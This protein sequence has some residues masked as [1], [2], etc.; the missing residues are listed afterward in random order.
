MR[1]GLFIT[2]EGPDGAGKTTQINRL[3]DYLA[4]MGMDTVLTR[5]PGGTQIGEKIREIILDPHHKEMAHLTEAL[6]YASS[7]A[8]H[9]AEKIRPALNAGK[10]VICDRFMDSSIAYQGYGRKLGERVRIINEIAVE[11][12]VPD[13][14]FLLLVDPDV[15]K[16]RISNGYLDRLELEAIHYHRDVYQGYLKLADL[17]PERILCIDGSRGVEEISSEIIDKTAAFLGKLRG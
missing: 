10:T 16:K 1:T 4:S 6:L 9:V 17:Y 13:L 7:R 2:F 12:L 11:G 8:Q 5:E 14:T 15:G 3:T